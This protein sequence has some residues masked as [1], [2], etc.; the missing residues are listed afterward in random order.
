[1]TWFG[2]TTPSGG[3]QPQTPA[4]SPIPL[5]PPPKNDED[6]EKLIGE[7]REAARQAGMQRDDPMMPL[8]NAIA[9]AI[10]FL[11]VRNT[12]S[13]RVTT[14]TSQRIVDTLAASRA[15]ATAQVEHFRAQLAATEADTIQRIA[16]SI[17]HSADDALRQRM[18]TL[19][20]AVYLTAAGVLFFVAIGCLTGGYWW[21]HHNVYYG[22][23][24]FKAG[25]RDIFD[26]NPEEAKIWP[27]LIAWNTLTDFNHV[28]KDNKIWTISNRRFCV[29]ELWIDPP[30]LP[31]LVV[32]PSPATDH[33]DSPPQPN[34]GPTNAPAAQPKLVAS[35]HSGVKK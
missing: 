25:L 13:E 33:Q 12:K 17:A 1:M 35:P 26:K 16:A 29:M 34:N 18:V 10:R 22:I 19:G 2:K 24:E 7:L 31:P 9:R 15:A 14:E 21:G 8:L 11:D 6:V 27:G 28:C 20:H 23:P 5:T 4:L 32:D 30:G 3:N